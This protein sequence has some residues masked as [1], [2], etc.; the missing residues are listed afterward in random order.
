[1]TEEQGLVCDTINGVVIFGRA[2]VHGVRVS[3]AINPCSFNTRAE[4]GVVFPDERGG[5]SGGGGGGVLIDYASGINLSMCGD[6]GQIYFGNITFS[7]L[8]EIALMIA[9]DSRKEKNE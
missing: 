4:R 7:E 2:K 3:L 9:M 6:L 1:M 8:Q 5:V